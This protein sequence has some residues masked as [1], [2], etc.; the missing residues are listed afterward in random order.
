MRKSLL[1]AAMA[2][3]AF[4]SCTED[5]IFTNDFN[6]ERTIAFSA[7]IV[8]PNT[9]A[10]KE[11]GTTYDTN[12]SFRVWGHY[13]GNAFNYYNSGVL[14]INNALCEYDGTSTWT[15]SN[16]R[17]TYY[18]PK[19]GT[20][21]FI[22][23]SP[24]DAED[25]CA[26]TGNKIKYTA[27]GITIDDY[28][29][30]TNPS[31]MQDLMFSERVYDRT[32]TNQNYLEGT[33]TGVDLQFRHALSSI[34]FKV[35]QGN[36]TPGTEVTITG[37]KLKNVKSKG[38]FNQNLEDRPGCITNLGTAA[39]PPTNMSQTV[40][41]WTLDSTKAD[42]AVDLEHTALKNGDDY[43]TPFWPCTNS[44]IAPTVTNNFRDTDLL[45]LPQSQSGIKLQIDYTVK[46]PDMTDALPQQHTVDLSGTWQIG[47]RYVYT[48][49]ISFNPITLAPVVD[50]D[51]SDVTTPSNP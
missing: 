42:Y 3:M 14:Y 11:H 1:I 4:T 31:N 12:S 24:A 29:V 23:Y 44:F 36:K 16:G 41:A 49:T 33:Y 34:V 22:A 21:T 9:R 15:P 46:S 19:N 6:Q 13:Y 45:L 8:A 48:I 40:A 38:D 32:P 20:L 17:N 28:T 51:W 27:T 5:E 39:T 37:I 7:P 35:V 43:A 10:A 47:H 2:C 50:V 26:S 30:P 18:W 25:K